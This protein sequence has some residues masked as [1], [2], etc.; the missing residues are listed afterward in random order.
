VLEKIPA[1]FGR[2]IVSDVGWSDVGA[3]EALKEALEDSKQH[4]VTKGEVH[5]IGGTDNLI[6]DYQGKKV[7]VAIDLDDMLVVNT[8]DVLLISKKSSAS[9]I[10][11]VVEGFAGTKYEELT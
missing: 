6:M 7:I 8:D 10:K 11:K 2:V 3:W 4:T 9:K 5:M 1:D